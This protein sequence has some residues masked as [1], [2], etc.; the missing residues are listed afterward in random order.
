MKTK[1]FSIGI[2]MTLPILAQ[3]NK[4]DLDHF[5]KDAKTIN[6]VNYPRTLSEFERISRDKEESFKD[7]INASFTKSSLLSDMILNIDRKLRNKRID[8]DVYK[9]FK[10]V[11]IRDAIRAQRDDYKDITTSVKIAEDYLSNIDAASFKAQFLDKNDSIESTILV[12]VNGEKKQ[13]SRSD[14]HVTNYTT[15]SKTFDHSYYQDKTSESEF[16]SLIALQDIEAESYEEK[17]PDGTIRIGFYNEEYK[18]E[19]YTFVFSGNKSTCIENT[20]PLE[21][22]DCKDGSDAS[23]IGIIKHCSKKSK[24]CFVNDEVWSSFS[25][26]SDRDVSST[27]LKALD[28]NMF[29]ETPLKIV[30]GGDFP[31]HVQLN[32]EK[33]DEIN[34]IAKEDAKYHGLNI[35]RIYT[36]YSDKTPL[37]VTFEVNDK[38]CQKAAKEGEECLKLTEALYFVIPEEFH[39]KAISDITIAHRQNKKDNR[40]K[41][42]FDPSTGHKEKDNYPAFIAA[43]AFSKDFPYKFA[44]RYWGSH[45]SGINGGKYSEHKKNGSW[46]FDNLYEWPLHGHRSHNQKANKSTLPLKAEYLRIFADYG[47][48]DDIIDYDKAYVHSITISYVPEVADFYETW[49]FTRSKT[50]MGDPQ[51]MKGRVYGGGPKYNGTYPGAVSL[52]RKVGNTSSLRGTNWIASRKGHIEYALPVGKKLKSI[53]VAAGDT[54]P[55]GKPNKDGGTGSLGGAKLTVKLSSSDGNEYLIR[56]AN[57]G[58]KGVITGFPS[59]LDRTIK[60]GDTLKIYSKS[61]TAYIMGIRIGYG[62]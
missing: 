24:Q 43:Q 52:R 8:N 15:Q 58:P 14:Y 12:K 3:A 5:Q 25:K 28:D 54:H 17:R 48:N 53:E 39:D 38:N 61:D 44:W 47:K 1:V 41:D 59:D 56:H 51:T 20:G 49:S 4:I 45:I 21:Y 6:G 40:G 13:G 7:F 37:S 60:D 35:K 9:F 30:P 33:Y 36:D 22:R 46:E 29:F 23:L 18:S 10:E 34:N 62:D 50:K 57:L 19:R 32:D 42:S 27:Y 11:G 55:D 26:F 2:L 31:A 16:I